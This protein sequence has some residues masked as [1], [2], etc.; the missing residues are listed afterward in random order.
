MDT[1]ENILYHTLYVRLFTDVAHDLRDV[2]LSLSLMT[3]TE[4]M[5]FCYFARRLAQNATERMIAN[6]AV[7][8]FDQEVLLTTSPLFVPLD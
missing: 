8:D 3:R 5:A 4:Q 6:D 7:T 1:V 2:M